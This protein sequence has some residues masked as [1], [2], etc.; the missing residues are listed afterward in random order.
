MMIGVILT[1]TM[2]KL[3][4]L[5]LL[6]IITTTCVAAGENLVASGKSKLP[7]GCEKSAETG[8]PLERRPVHAVA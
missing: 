8:K 7:V 5:F 4:G 2:R 6:S 1:D 3:P